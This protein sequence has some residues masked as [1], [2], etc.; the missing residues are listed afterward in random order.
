MFHQIIHF[1]AISIIHLSAR[2]YARRTTLGNHFHW[3]LSSC[4][5]ILNQMLC[6]LH[7]NF[8]NTIPGCYNLI[9]Y[10]YYLAIY[11]FIYLSI[12][13]T[14]CLFFRWYVLQDFLCLVAKSYFYMQLCNI[15]NRYIVSHN[16]II[17]NFSVHTAAYHHVSRR[18]T[19]YPHLLG[20]FI[21]MSS[22]NLTIV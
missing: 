17:T 20:N 16:C 21:Y 10:Y 7:N 11:L 8:I 13:H 1:Q 12:T 2:Y 18:K 5:Q 15:C 14:S 19:G 6:F 22:Y 9:S 4:E 3:L